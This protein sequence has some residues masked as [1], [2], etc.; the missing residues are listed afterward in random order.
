MQLVMAMLAP[1]MGRLKSRAKI[2]AM[3]FRNLKLE[4]D[5]LVDDLMLSL[6]SSNLLDEAQRRMDDQ[7]LGYCDKAM[8]RKCIDKNRRHKK[9]RE[10]LGRFGVVM[11]EE[12]SEQDP[13][14]LAEHQEMVQRVRDSIDEVL[15]PAER[16]VIMMHFAE[17]LTLNEIADA[18]EKSKSSVK[19]A[20]HRAM[21]K[22][23]AE[24]GVY[25]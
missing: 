4:A 6:A 21:M 15:T 14:Y 23:R 24:A 1:I 7:L 5:D 17:G 20:M 16:Q 10:M 25:Q 3:S 8:L 2:I 9:E 22:L 13:A 11:D 12:S 18:L 19:G